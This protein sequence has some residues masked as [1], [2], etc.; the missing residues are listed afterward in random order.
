MNDRAHPPLLIA[1][2]LVAGYLPG[3]DILN[4]IDL[5]LGTGEL[6][7][8]IGNWSGSS[9]PTAPANPPS[10]RPCSDS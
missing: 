10:S 3:V 7:G 8:I 6:V 2:D 9:D 4:G 1:E 5:T